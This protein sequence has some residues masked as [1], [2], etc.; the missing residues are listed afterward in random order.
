MLVFKFGFKLIGTGVAISVLYTRFSI[1][2]SY[3]QDL[4]MDMSFVSR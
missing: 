3:T 4:P 1:D 2:K